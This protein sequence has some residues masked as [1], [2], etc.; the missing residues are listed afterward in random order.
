LN[1]CDKTI[2]CNL[3]PIIGNFYLE[4]ILEFNGVHNDYILKENEYFFDDYKI[5]ENYYNNKN[6]C[7]TEPKS[8]MI[9]ILCLREI[10]KNNINNLKMPKPIIKYIVE[11]TID[12][13]FIFKLK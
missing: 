6:Y 13:I 5:I 12:K 7:Y 3:T 11:M 8:I 4:N 9:S 10:N 1:N 2:I